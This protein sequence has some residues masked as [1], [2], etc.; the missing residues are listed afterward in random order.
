[1]LAGRLLM[2]LSTTIYVVASRQ[3]HVREM[4]S[5]KSGSARDDDPH[6]DTHTIADGGSAAAV[7]AVIV[8]R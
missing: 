4:R 5:D 1:M 7:G 6:A 3:Q 8:S 2:K